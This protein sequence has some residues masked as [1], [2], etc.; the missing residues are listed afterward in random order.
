MHIIKLSQNFMIRWIFEIYRSGL[1]TVILTEKTQHFNIAHISI[2]PC[3]G[4]IK[5]MC[6]NKIFCKYMVEK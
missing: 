4:I 5:V 1:K 2:L 6:K 3:T